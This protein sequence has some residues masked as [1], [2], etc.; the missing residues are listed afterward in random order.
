[1]DTYI[2]NNKGK[3]FGAYLTYAPNDDFFISFAAINGP[4]SPRPGTGDPSNSGFGGN[5]ES[6]EVF[7]Y[8]V[9]LTYA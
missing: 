8:N 4:E 3:S 1:M 6:D 7:M 2:D 9:V 5:S